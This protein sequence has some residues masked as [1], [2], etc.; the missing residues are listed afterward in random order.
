MIFL[1]GKIYVD[2]YLC[3]DAGM[4]TT[5]PA[6]GSHRVV[7]A[8]VLLNT[9]V[10]SD[11]DGRRDDSARIMEGVGWRDGGGEGGGWVWVWVWVW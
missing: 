3:A 9:C 2:Y 11:R 8:V 4:T 1:N 10:L 7:V 5:Q 6:P